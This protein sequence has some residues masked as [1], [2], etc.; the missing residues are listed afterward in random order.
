MNILIYLN[1]LT[2]KPNHNLQYNIGTDFCIEAP[3]NTTFQSTI[4]C[5]LTQ[6]PQLEPYFQWTVTLNGTNLSY[7]EITS[8]GLSVYANNGTFNL[9]GT[10]SIDQ[11]STLVV[12]CEVSNIFGNDTETTSISLCGKSACILLSATTILCEKRCL[13]MRKKVFFCHSASSRLQPQ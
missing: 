12:T 9:N 6:K 4:N 8:F 11:T 5:P 1:L 10:I 7:E 2:A 13:M 3:V